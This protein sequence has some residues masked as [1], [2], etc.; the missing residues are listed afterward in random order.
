MT[1]QS[2]RAFIFARGGSK[3]VPR[4]NLRMLGD[5]PLIAHSI[6]CAIACPALGKVAVSTDDPEIAEISKAWGAD[7]PFM[8]PPELATDTASEWDAWK[9]AITWFEHQ[10]NPFDV[11]VSLPATSPLREVID[12]ET[13]LAKL[14]DHPEA[15]AVI[16]VKEAERSPFFNMVKLDEQGYASLVS[17]GLSVQRRQDAPKV[18]DITTVAYAVRTKFIMNSTGLFPSRSLTVMVPPERALDIDVP[19]D[20]LLAELLVEHKHKKGAAVVDDC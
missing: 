2:I 10:G 12:V 4:K 18:F 14:L 11:L 8:R 5:K 19:Y 7:V 3:G 1:D 6:Q 9:H 13:C 20:F 17:S 16:A 15:D